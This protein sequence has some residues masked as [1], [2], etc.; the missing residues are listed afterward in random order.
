[1]QD[2]ND[3]WDPVRVDLAADIPDDPGGQE[4]LIGRLEQHRR[5]LTQARTTLRRPPVAP[6][7]VE[8]LAHT[9]EVDIDAHTSPELRAA[10]D[11]LQQAAQH[12]GELH[13]QAALALTRLATAKERA[14]GTFDDVLADL[15]GLTGRHDQLRAAHLTLLPGLL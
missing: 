4:A 2:R 11:V 9:V 15:E 7:T 14:D 10:Q 6:G 1:M 8:R 5:A 12:L 13:L 3:T